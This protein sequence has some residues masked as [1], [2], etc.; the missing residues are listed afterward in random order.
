[1]IVTEQKIRSTMASLLP[2]LLV[3]LLVSASSSL[4]SEDSADSSSSS[5]SLYS[6]HGKVYPPDN[7]LRH[8]PDWY[9]K[10]KVSVDGGR[11]VGFVKEDNTFVVHG[12]PSGSYVVEVVNP[13]FAYEPVRVDINSKGKMRARK[14]NNVQPTQVTQVAYPLKMKPLGKFK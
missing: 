2:S 14:V 8:D 6:I 7:Q 13:D 10:T 3:C 4:A 11:K 1:M 9:W 5:P 12:L